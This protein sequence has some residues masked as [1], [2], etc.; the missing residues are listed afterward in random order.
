MTTLWSA[1]PASC[2]DCRS[3]NGET[4]VFVSA[5]GDTH[6]L[7]VQASLVLAMLLESPE[8]ARSAPA[9]LDII[10]PA[11]DQSPA[12]EADG[13]DDD[14]LEQLLLGLEKIGVVRRQPA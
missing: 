8:A 13:K 3:W 7:S 9:W 10:F 12:D 5:S 11:D 4:V 1:G 6:A 2:F 14:K